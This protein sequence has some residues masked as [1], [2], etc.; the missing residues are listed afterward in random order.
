METT[1]I[2]LCLLCMCVACLLVGT[3]GLYL[4]IRHQDRLE[5]NMFDKLEAYQGE[6]I[7]LLNLLYAQR[8]AMR[9][10]EEFQRF[11]DEIQKGNVPN[12]TNVFEQE[13]ALQRRP[14][15]PPQPPFEPPPQGPG[16]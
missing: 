6:M 5:S 13:L 12:L 2:L 15:L 14:P 7:K 4:V 1:T 9:Q 16:C 8:N 10:A 3:Y 11:L